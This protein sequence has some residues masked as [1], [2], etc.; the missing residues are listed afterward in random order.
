MFCIS[1]GSSFISGLVLNTAVR[2]K[3]GV[4]LPHLGVWMEVAFISA[5]ATGYLRYDVTKL[6]PRNGFNSPF[7][8][9]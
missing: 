1:P 9:P 4:G 3:G 5:Q 7:N 2:L 8:S 6:M